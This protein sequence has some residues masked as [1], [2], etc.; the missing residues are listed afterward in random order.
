MYPKK[1]KEFKSSKLELFID[2]KDFF[3]FSIKS[4]RSP[5]TFLMYLHK[6]FHF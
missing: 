4:F 2:V 3:K 5:K 1:T 6:N